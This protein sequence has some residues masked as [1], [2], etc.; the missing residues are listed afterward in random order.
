M[1]TH[2]L[3]LGEDCKQEKALSRISTLS[4]NAELPSQGFAAVADPRYVGGLVTSDGNDQVY[5]LRPQGP[6]RVGGDMA[7]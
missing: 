4:L 6:I 1:G 2:G 5:K 3:V 7:P